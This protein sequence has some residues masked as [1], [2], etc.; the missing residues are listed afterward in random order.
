MKNIII[1]CSFLPV[2]TAKFNKFKCKSRWHKL[3]TSSYSAAKFAEK[4]LWFQPEY[5]PVSHVSRTCCIRLSVLIKTHSP[6]FLF[7]Y[8]IF[9]RYVQDDPSKHTYPHATTPTH[10][11]NT[12]KTNRALSSILLSP[13]NAFITRVLDTAVYKGDLSTFPI[14][15]KYVFL[16]LLPFELRLIIL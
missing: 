9:L 16:S 11:I 13:H 14:S 12:W 15:S 5:Q 8:L 2:F 3:E 4:V 6:L 10:Y 1:H 7:S